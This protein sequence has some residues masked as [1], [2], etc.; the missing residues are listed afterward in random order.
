MTHTGYEGPEEHPEPA[1]FKFERYDGWPSTSGISCRL[2]RNDRVVG[3]VNLETEGE[4]LFLKSRI[5]G[6]YDPEIE[7]VRNDTRRTDEGN[8]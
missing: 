8:R 4:Y 7:D 1:K 5:D 3:M 2:L 6:T